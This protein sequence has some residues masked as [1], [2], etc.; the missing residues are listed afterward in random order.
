MGADRPS[1]VPGGAATPEPVSGL[2]ES[3]MMGL[4]G[5]APA[6]GESVT[7]TGFARELDKEACPKFTED[8]GT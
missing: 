8:G 7:M 6:I 2:G 5:W 4:L 3:S 1:V